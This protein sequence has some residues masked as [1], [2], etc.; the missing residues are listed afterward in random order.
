MALKMYNQ[1][2]EELA[3]FDQLDSPDTYFQYY[4]E[5]SKQGYHGMHQE[6]NK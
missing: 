4:P 3:P 2:L 5:L 6:A 1:L